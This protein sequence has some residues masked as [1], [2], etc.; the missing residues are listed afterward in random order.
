MTNLNDDLMKGVS[1]IAEFQGETV[2]R[3][4]YMLEKGMLP[5]F[6]R[7]SIWYARKSTILADIERREQEAMA[8]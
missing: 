8:G 2:R 5:G 7:G 4:Y 6:K 1:Q 3:T